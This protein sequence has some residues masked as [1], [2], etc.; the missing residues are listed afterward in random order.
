MYYRLVVLLVNAVKSFNNLND[1]SLLPALSCVQ[2]TL[3]HMLDMSWEPQDLSFFLSIDLPELLLSMSKQNIST[4]DSVVSQWEEDD[5][6]ADYR[7]NLQWLEECKDG[8]F[9]IWYEKINQ[10]DPDVKRKNKYKC[11]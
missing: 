4:H 3:L 7:Q 10:A 6:R 2:T 11:M 8:M 9:E 5:E 1:R